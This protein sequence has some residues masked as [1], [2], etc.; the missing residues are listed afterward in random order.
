MSYTLKITVL[1]GV[2]AGDVFKFDL[3]SDQSVTIGREERNQIVLS[4]PRV[5]RVHAE[6]RAG[7]DGLVIRDRG[8]SGGTIH[9]GFKLTEE[10]RRLSPGDEFKIADMLFRADIEGSA[11]GKAAPSAESATAAPEAAESP[12]VATRRLKPTQLVVIGLLLVLLLLLL[13]W[14]TSE[15]PKLPKQKSD[16]VL[17]MPEYS[18]LG[19]LPGTK[20]TSKKNKDNSRLDK[21]QFNLPS[22]NVLIEYDY[23]SDAELHILVDETLVDTL[24]PSAGG[25]HHRELIARDVFEGRTRRLVFDNTAYPPKRG[26]KN[27]GR[28][29][30]WA[31]RNVR[32]T[33]LPRAGDID[34]QLSDLAAIAMGYDRTPE[35]LSVLIRGLQQLLLEALDELKQDILAIPVAEKDK[36]G[37]E[38]LN[39]IE[40]KDTLLAVKSER[41]STALAAETSRLHVK[42]LAELLG[43]LEAELWRRTESNFRRAIY[44][45]KAENHIVVFDNLLAVKMMFRDESDYRWLKADR[46]INDNKYV[47]KKI[48]KNPAKYR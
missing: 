46:M 41:S 26:S 19:Y 36:I 45:A 5:S 9:M 42:V 23:R 11:L 38:D 47:P 14:P 44:A 3:D 6:I 24:P 43:K 8:S 30:Q 29:K 15:G 25:W 34:Q 33:P 17:D 37:P 32:A 28:I 18:V 27:A 10:P 7:E 16:Q 20:K 2:S 35:G 22:S 13:I 31:V 40:I 48:R 12:A 4:D 39:P 21:V 1:S